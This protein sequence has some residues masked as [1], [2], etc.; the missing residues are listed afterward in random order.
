M[1]TNQVWLRKRKCNVHVGISGRSVEL[2]IWIP[3][4]VAKNMIL[5]LKRTN[6]S[7]KKK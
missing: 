5:Q 7:K 2:R 4:S 3:A 6:K 1:A